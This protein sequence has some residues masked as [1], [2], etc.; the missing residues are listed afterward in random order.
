MEGDPGFGE[1]VGFSESPPPPAGLPEAGGETL[2]RFG[3]LWIDRRDWI[4]RLAEK[5]RRGEMSDALSEL[6][7]RFVRDGYAILPGA[8]PRD[9]V[10][11]VNRDI[12]RCWRAPPEAMRIEV[13]ID[14][15]C[16]YARPAIEHRAGTSKLLDL[17]AFSAAARQAIAAPRLVAFLSAIFESAPRAFQSLSFHHGSAQAMHK[18]SAYVQV[19]RNPL[20]MAAAW[21][22]L[23]DVEPGAGPLEYYVGSHRAPDF[24]FAGSSK[25]LKT[26]PDEH[27]RFLDSLH[28]DAQ[29]YR[30]RRQSFLGR[31]GD[32]LVW[33]ADLA[34]GG[35]AIKV[36]ERTRRSLVTHFTTAQDEPPYR[37]HQ[38]HEE[39]RQ[40]GCIFIA[41][42]SDVGD[43]LANP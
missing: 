18:D 19:A 4:D 32:V 9:L 24:L 33:H 38:Q 12:E 16:Q 17:H 36:P 13:Y 3:G 15:R 27:Q 22:A 30:H 29:K 5:H 8:V 26:A 20:H 28:E 40:G 1:I 37:R 25:W 7:F 6:I 39:G 11:R 41:Q 34:H 35:S 2:S 21:L 10:D 43:A 23:E 31:C 42:F 14:D